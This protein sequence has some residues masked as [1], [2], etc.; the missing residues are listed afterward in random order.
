MKKWKIISLTAASLLGLTIVGERVALADNVKPI[1]IEV[2]EKQSKEI[3]SVQKEI[4]AL[5]E[6]N[7]R[8]NNTISINEGNKAELE[9][10]IQQKEKEI[11]RIQS[12]F[13]SK[14]KIYQENMD[15]AKNRMVTLQVKNSPFGIQF[16]ESLL[17]SESLSNLV[18]RA[19]GMTLL[20]NSHTSF[21]NHLV[22]ERIQIENEKKIVTKEQ[23]E[24]K[25]HKKEAENLLVQLEIDKNT[26]VKQIEDLE[27][28]KKKLTEEYTASN[29][30]YQ[31][32]QENSR[33]LDKSS[34]EKK[35]VDKIEKRIVEKK[36]DP[37]LEKMPLEKEI[38][39]DLEELLED[40]PNPDQVPEI[41]LLSFDEMPQT[42]QRSVLDNLQSELG[43][44]P[45]TDR[46][47]LIQQ[48]LDD[49]VSYIGVPYRW[50][51]STPSGFDCS[52]LV[53]YVY[54]KSG[55]NLPRVT[56]DQEKMG[57]S[58]SLNEVEPG[59]LLFWGERGN[60]YHNA[61][62]I[63]DE[64]FIHSPKPGKNVQIMSFSEFMPKFARR[65][66]QKEIPALPDENGHQLTPHDLEMR[67]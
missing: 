34:S 63:G 17:E 22:E 38:V 16:V 19:Y 29:L 39:L 36:D 27:N 24:V 11:Q 66:I 28:K 5:E 13:D 21:M 23:E 48:I 59:D 64:K 18:D 26:S 32:M 58:I 44:R 35:D 40:D 52:G 67:G 20:L 54:A 46:N 65:V 62:Y 10:I 53:Q 6:E 2:L 51:G 8:L 7:G 47:N 57:T 50:G 33:T 42:L 61:I 9:E 31:S 45:S 25:Q 60:S 4:A 56:T 1:S 43:T 12:I 14:M 41:A 30:T 15:V 55:I 3:I 49:A 37:S